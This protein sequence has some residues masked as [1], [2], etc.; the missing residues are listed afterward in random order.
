MEKEREAIEVEVNGW[1]R[2]EL[3][4]I[5]VFWLVSWGFPNWFA[6]ILWHTLL[7]FGYS[8]KASCARPGE[9]VIC[10]FWHPG[11]L[12]LSPERQS[13]RMSKIT[14][15]GFT[16][17]G[18]GCF[19]SVPICHM[20]T[21]GTEGLQVAWSCAQ[22]YPSWL[23]VMND[24]G[25]G[26]TEEPGLWVPVEYGRFVP[27]VPVRRRAVVYTASSGRD[28]LHWWSDGISSPAWR[29][30]HHVHHAQGHSCI[31]SLE[32]S[33]ELTPMRQCWRSRFLKT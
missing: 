13:A 27:S 31:S 28:S 15:D 6:M 24:M 29:A 32:L 9:A 21:V 10:I 5:G 22:S 2:N 30:R 16:R 12:T 18:T 3:R 19:I 8:C 25:A 1:C 26:C 14:N 20:A 17:S 23:V 11:T 33:V 7:P 4:M